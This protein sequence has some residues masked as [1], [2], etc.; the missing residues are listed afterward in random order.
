MLDNEEDLL[1]KYCDMMAEM[2]GIVNEPPTPIIVTNTK[3][4]TAFEERLLWDA[5]KKAALRRVSPIIIAPGSPKP[6]L[7]IML[8]IT[9]F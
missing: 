8:F 1:R 7:A 3:F 5:N 4:A 2:A 6:M 9:I